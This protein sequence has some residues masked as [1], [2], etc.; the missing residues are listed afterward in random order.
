[1]TNQ[2]Q[3]KIIKIGNSRGVRIPQTLLVQAGLTDEVEMMVEGERLVIQ[4]LHM[5]REGWNEQFSNMA[6]QGDDHL[7]DEISQN[8]RWDEV[9]WEW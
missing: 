7:V 6:L 4:P 2:Y 9:E 8:S 5:V 1:M 3:T